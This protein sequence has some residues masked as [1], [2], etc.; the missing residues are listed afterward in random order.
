MGVLWCWVVGVWCV[1]CVWCVG[2]CGLVGVGW[3]VVAGVCVVVVSD[4]HVSGLFLFPG[5]VF[6]FVLLFG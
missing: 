2:G 1:W 3:R 6:C 5:F 4:A